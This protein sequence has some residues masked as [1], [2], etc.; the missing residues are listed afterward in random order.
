M[1]SKIIGLALFFS[2]MNYAYSQDYFL[3]AGEVVGPYPAI[4]TSAEKKDIEE[5]LYYQKTR[6]P[7][8]CALAAKEENSSI[9]AFFGGPDGLLTPDEV[10]QVRRKLTLL[11]IKTGAE[12]YFIK[13]KYSRPRPY[14]TH[15]EIRPCIALENSKSYPSGHATIS[16]L[17]ARVL[18]V[19][20]PERKNQFLERADVIAFH[21]V[22]GGVHHPSDIEAGKIFGD[23][24]ADEYLNEN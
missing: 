5:L 16:R 17:Y 9:E 10:K 4:G 23:A 11:T 21:R 18:G 12:I 2:T 22:L 8:D 14:I 7:E 15:P 1:K 24:L 20:F 6:T 19:I 13:T 3:G